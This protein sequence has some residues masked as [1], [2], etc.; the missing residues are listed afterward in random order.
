M[1]VRNADAGAA[2]AGMA[3][4]VNRRGG[5]RRALG[6]LGASW[7]K[8]LR[9]GR[10]RGFGLADVDMTVEDVGAL[11]RGR[12]YAEHAAPPQAAA[13]VT[14]PRRAHVALGLLPA[15]ARGRGGS[16]DVTQADGL[17]PIIVAE[18]VVQGIASMAGSHAPANRAD[19]IHDCP[20]VLDIVGVRPSV[21]LEELGRIELLAIALVSDDM[22]RSHGVL[23]VI[24]GELRLEVRRNIALL[25]ELFMPLAADVVPNPYRHDH[26]KE[27]GKE[28]IVDVS[29][30]DVRHVSCR[31]LQLE[32]LTVHPCG[33]CPCRAVATSRV[34]ST[35]SP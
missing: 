4:D 6:I 34:V 15:S 14:E 7:G 10:A 13:L 23:R 35:C 27:G 26:A 30:S 3:V 22:H 31:L 25:A 2:D 19:A 11:G 18:V 16:G 8:N 5:R 33:G 17:H 28:H 21:V 20:S 1:S 12:S 24:H 29:K 9:S 32:R